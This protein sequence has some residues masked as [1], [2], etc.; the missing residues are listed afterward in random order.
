[1]S[2]KLLRW[3]IR[4]MCPLR[5][6]VTLQSLVA[7]VYPALEAIQS[8]QNAKMTSKHVTAKVIARS[9]Y[10]RMLCLHISPRWHQ[11]KQLHRSSRQGSRKKDVDLNYYTTHSQLLAINGNSISGSLKTIKLYWR[12]SSVTNG[13]RI[14]DPLSFKFEGNKLQFVNHVATDV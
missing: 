4:V 9:Q 3:T 7:C 10:D 6:G 2:L 8:L 14:C 13:K 11:Q 1:M 5:C 12:Q